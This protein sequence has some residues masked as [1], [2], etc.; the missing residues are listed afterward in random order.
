[1][2]Q[3][4]APDTIISNF[5]TIDS[6]QT[7]PTIKSVHA[8]AKA[9]SY[10]PLNLSK[11]I[12]GAVVNGTPVEKIECVSPGDVIK[13]RICFDN[14]DNDYAVT[15]VSIVD[16]LPKGM[17]FVTADGNGVS[18]H[19]DV[20]AHTYTWLYPVLLPEASACLQLVVQVNEDAAP[21]TMLTNSATISS[22]QTPPTTVHADVVTC[23]IPLQAELCIVPSV[24]RSGSFGVPSKILA[25]VAL[26]PGV[27]KTDM[28]GTLLTLQPGAIEASDQSIHD[29]G[30]RVK[31][32]AFFDK[33]R[34]ISA[35]GGYGKVKLKVAGKLKS[36]RS[37]VGEEFVYITR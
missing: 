13:Y 23:G 15:S 31:V 8:V 12:V 10:S 30:K 35:A 27:A 25:I 11:D 33:A 20:N 37:F 14:N 19:Y 21:D 1:V 6:D 16:I 22:D 36:G 17:S 32:L 5:V 18:G 2:K 34:L 9:V 3:D 28:E 26:P 29:T 24:I 7:P 4:T